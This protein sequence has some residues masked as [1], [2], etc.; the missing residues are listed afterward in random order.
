MTVVKSK[1]K[2]GWFSTL[3]HA[4]CWNLPRQM[5]TAVPPSPATRRVSDLWVR[6]TKRV[7]GGNGLEWP[8]N[9]LHCP[10]TM[11]SVKV[12]ESDMTRCGRK[13]RHSRLWGDVIWSIFGLSEKLFSSSPK[14]GMHSCSIQRE[15]TATRLCSRS[16]R[17]KVLCYFSQAKCLWRCILA[18]HPIGIGSATTFLLVVQNSKFRASGLSVVELLLLYLPALSVQHRVPST[19]SIFLFVWSL[20]YFWCLE[21][22]DAFA[23]TISGHQVND[24]VMPWSGPI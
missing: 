15:M 16:R 22:H 14:F 8:E 11:M 4:S 2:N 21:S 9:C 10:A 3:C 5:D 17:S 1:T 24:I 13:E 19:V 12:L 6:G 20:F 23:F 18:F 7:G